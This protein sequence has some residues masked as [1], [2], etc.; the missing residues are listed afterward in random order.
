MTAPRRCRPGVPSAVHYPHQP[1]GGTN[2]TVNRS[3]VIASSINSLAAAILKGMDVPRAPIA[4]N[5]RA[6]LPRAFVCFFVPGG[7]HAFSAWRAGDL[8]IR[9]K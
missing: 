6:N 5:A 4:K 2:W 1:N 9:L 8:T 3:R 7:F